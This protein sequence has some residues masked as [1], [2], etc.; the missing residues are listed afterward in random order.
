V[1]S[2]VVAS[3][4]E[5][6]EGSFSV[7]ALRSALTPFGPGRLEGLLVAVGLD[8]C[9]RE[10]IWQRGFRVHAAACTGV[11]VGA[12]EARPRGLQGAYPATLP[13]SAASFGMKLVVDLSDGPSSWRHSNPSRSRV[14]LF[15]S[16]VLWVPFA[17]PQFEL[18]S[19]TGSG[20]ALLWEPDA[21]GLVFR[22]GPEFHF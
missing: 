17:S 21:V 8:M 12:L 10:P 9:L 19:R 6:Y 22:L 1:G 11:T 3:L 18:Q 2:A 5:H 13:Y 4:K 14:A 15:V 20:G 7:T 16:S